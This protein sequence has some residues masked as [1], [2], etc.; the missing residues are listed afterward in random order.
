MTRVVHLV[1]HTHWDREWYLP[2]QTFRLR[3]VELIDRV[4][5]WMDEDER[6]VFTLDGQLA[7]VDDY[8]E[9]RPEAEERIRRLV[10]ANR[11]AIGPWQILMDEFLVSGESMVRNLERGL[12]RAEE[13]GGAMPVGYLPDMFGHVAQMPQLLARA[14]IEHAVVWRGV[15]AAIEGH[16][17]EWG[18]PDGSS[19]RTEYL[20]GG[21]GNAANLLEAPE[22]LDAKVELLDRA[23]RPFFGDDE[24]LALYGT[25]HTE[26]LPGFVD[27]VDRLNA[28]QSRYRLELSTLA[29]YF[30]RLP[31]G[32]AGLPLWRGELRSGARA[33]LLMG[34]TSARIDIKAACGRAERLLERYAEPFQALYGEGRPEPLLDLAW[35]RMIDNSAHDSICGCSADAVSRQVLVRFDEAEQIAAGLAERAAASVASRVPSGTV[36]VLNPSPHERRGLVELDMSI[37]DDWADVAL[38]LPDGRRVSTQAVEREEPLLL[39]EELRAGD[40][41]GFIARRLHGRELFGRW[42]NGFRLEDVE[43]TRRLTLELGREPDPE[44]LDVDELTGQIELAAQ[45]APDETWQLRALGHARRRLLADVPAP[46]LGWTAARAVE[47]TGRLENPVAVRGHTLANG[48][49]EAAVAPDGTV[50]LGGA[51]GIGRLVDGGDRGDSYN[52]AP[53]ERDT[54][55]EEPESVEIEVRASGPVRGELAVVRAYHWP[56]GLAPDEESRSAETVPVRVTTNV[57]L[58]AGEPF[59]RLR[60][61]FDNPSTDHRLRLHVPLPREAAGSAAEGQ[62]AVVER[63]L[64]AEGGYGEVPL[65]TFPARG[66]VDAGGIAVLLEHVSEYEVVGGRELALTILRSIGLISRNDN[67]WREEPAGP[68]VELPEAQCRGPWSFGLA[69]FPHEGSWADSGVLT[70]MERYRHP[71]LTAPGTG[72]DGALG[73]QAGPSLEGEGVVL[74]SLRRR[75][76]RLELRLACEQPDAR[77]ATVSGGFTEAWEADLLGRPGGPIALEAGAL[78]L[79]LGPWEIR[80]VLVRV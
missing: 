37:P 19:V 30:E 15:P 4:L 66:F 55:V 80:T 36:A 71:F 75:G 11:L 38:E 62:F 68:E 49:L 17:F 54:L 42:L 46:P 76:D 5:D 16:A 34:V 59:L 12:R 22:R 1:P 53:P 43:G 67:P 7:T 33:N 61:S 26:P 14:G 2:F 21:Y 24:L 45:A 60:V 32:R 35:S 79:A 52:Y 23:M 3:L 31:D 74:S 18:S 48:L 20:P 70:Q 41:P 39:T 6:F 40:V 25:D 13:L 72:T 56:L 50:S 63:G 9:I 10:R 51:S 73:L 47:G 69:L 8:L 44:W 78:R 29:R 65:P 27:L 28:A 77:T 57:E 58:R 64:E